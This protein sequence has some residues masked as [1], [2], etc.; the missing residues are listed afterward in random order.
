MTER[1]VSRRS[2]LRTAGGL[3]TVGAL[4]SL[5]GCS[6]VQDSLGVGGGGPSSIDTVPEDSQYVL[7]VDFT[8]IYEDEALREGVNEELTTVREE[9][10]SDELPEDV[11][12]AL[13][14]IEDEAGLDPRSMSQAILSGTYDSDSEYDQ[15]AYTFWS[16]WSEDDLLETVEEEGGSYEEDEYGG[17]TVYAPEEETTTG[18]PTRMAVLEE[19]V[20]TVGTESHVEATI[21]TYT[22]EEDPLSGE[23]RDAY[24][25]STD[26]HLRY[27]FDVIESQVPEETGTQFDTGVFRETAYAYGSISPDGDD[28]VAT[29]KLEA[30]SE[31]DATDMGDIM[32]GAIT[33]GEGQIEQSEMEDKEQLLT[34]LEATEVEADGTTASVTHTRPAS[35]FAAIATPILLSFV[36]PQGGTTMESESESAARAP[37]ASFGFQF[38]EASGDNNQLAIAHEGGDTIPASQLFIRGSGFADVDGAGQTEAGPWKGTTTDG[39][40]S[41]GNIVYVGVRS[42]YE[43]SIVWRSESGD[44]GAVLA[45]ASGPDA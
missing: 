35:E 44:S 34:A 31:E 33:M 18:A 17:K 45:E 9:M 2:V 22:G 26:G 32:Q 6:Q 5:S 10:Q 42:D 41:A 1:S 37:Q 16:E 28:R 13:D 36:M 8:A 29:M 11:T 14:Q 4:G 39:N 20:F 43:I 3:A 25:A 21:D 23:V 19:G 30:S 40:V 15:A 24:D 7:E 38:Y 12:D 27:A